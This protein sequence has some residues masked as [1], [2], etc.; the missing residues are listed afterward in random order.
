MA[1]K[2]ECFPSLASTY[3]RIMRVV[4]RLRDEGDATP[5]HFGRVSRQVVAL[6]VFLRRHAAADILNIF[7]ANTGG[8][9]GHFSSLGNIETL[10][11]GPDQG[12]VF[13]RSVPAGEIRQFEL[14]PR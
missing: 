11:T 12:V 6:L 9:L 1:G 13:V 3:Q 4:S 14:P 7:F 2:G 8:F 5:V 10:G